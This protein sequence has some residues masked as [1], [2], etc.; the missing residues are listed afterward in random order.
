MLFF[1]QTL[2]TICTSAPIQCELDDLYPGVP[3][4]GIVW[5]DLTGF[6]LNRFIQ[7]WHLDEPEV[8]GRE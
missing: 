3:D 6:G 7:Q 1:S 4:R 8:S 2:G 5:E